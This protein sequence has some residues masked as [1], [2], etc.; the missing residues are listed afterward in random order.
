MLCLE[1]YFEMLSSAIEEKVKSIPNLVSV[2]KENVFEVPQN[3]F[4]ELE[5]AISEKSFCTNRTQCYSNRN[6]WYRRPKLVL[7]LCS[8]FD[9]CYHDFN[10]FSDE[11]YHQTVTDKDISFQ[12]YYS[13]DYVNEME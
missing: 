2:P 1:N 4:A 11:Q 8:G 7:C 12:R 10:L 13:S 3:Y 6:Q 5:I 9:F